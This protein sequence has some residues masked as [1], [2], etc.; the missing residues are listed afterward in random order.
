MIKSEGGRASAVAVDV[1][2]EPDLISMVARC[3]DEWGRIDVLHNN[4][5]V[6]HAGGDAPVTEITAEAFTH[7]MEINLR[8]MVLACKHALPVMREQGFGAIVNIASVAANINYPTVGYKTSKAG[9]VT[10]TEHLAITNAAYGI[11]AN[12]VLPGLVDTPMAVERQMQD[13]G[14]SRD[15]VVARRSAR[16][17]LKVRPGSAWDVAQ[18]A[19]FL[20]SDDAAF[21]TGAALTVDGGQS[22]VVR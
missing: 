21:I 13:S 7:I 14:L 15:D 10:L 19:L 22:L 11:R 17:P 16:T 9:V 6:S 1:K 20:A 18:A 5:G 4:V 8:G 3:M 2:Q 12:A